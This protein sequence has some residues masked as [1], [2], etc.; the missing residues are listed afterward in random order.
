MEYLETTF[1]FSPYPIDGSMVNLLIAQNKL[2]LYGIIKSDNT[3][4]IPFM[5]DDIQFLT[6][7]KGKT[8]F[9][10]KTGDQYNLYDMENNQLMNQ[11]FERIKLVGPGLFELNNESETYQFDLST[12]LLTEIIEKK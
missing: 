7:F 4:I 12:N 1:Q 2:R 9:A 11:S 8:V 5:Y 6:V 10:G 3:P